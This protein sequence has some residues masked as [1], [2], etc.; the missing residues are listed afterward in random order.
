MRLLEQVLADKRGEAAVL[1]KHGQA[2]IA[3][4]LE[5][6]AREVFE[7]AEPYLTFIPEADAIIRSNHRRPWFRARFAAW[8]RQGLARYSPTNKRE[9]QYCLLI[10]PASGNLD[11]VRADAKRAAQQQMEKAS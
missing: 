8:E 1:R 10:V 2:A 11:A 7:A 6:F 5:D 4:A 9:R 3:D